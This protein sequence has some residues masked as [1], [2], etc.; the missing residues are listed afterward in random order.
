MVLEVIGR[1]WRLLGGRK[2]PGLGQSASQRE[3]AEA[4][5]QLIRTG[6]RANGERRWAEAEKAY[7]QALQ[8][9]PRL[10][11]V[12]VQYGHSLKE[13]GHFSEA[14]DAYRRAIA[15][16]DS[17]ADT[18]LQLG[19]VLKL[20]NRFDAAITAYQA[21]YTH[22]RRSQDAIRELRALGAEPVIAI[23]ATKLFDRK[24]RARPEFPPDVIATRSD[25]ADIKALY[26]LLLGRFPENWEVFRDNRNRSIAD[27]TGDLV[28]SGEFYKLVLVPL[29]TGGS[30]RHVQLEQA[31][32]E[33]VK[34]WVDRLEGD[35]GDA[36]LSWTELLRRYLDREP[37]NKIFCEAVL[38]GLQPEL[39]QLSGRELIGRLF[40]QDG[41]SIQLLVDGDVVSEFAVNGADPPQGLTQDDASRF[42]LSIPVVAFDGCDHDIVVR[43]ARTQLPVPS[44]RFTARLVPS[45]EG[46]VVGSAARLKGWVR[47]TSSSEHHVAIDLRDG[48]RV[49]CSAV[50]GQPTA[51]PLAGDHG[52][53]LAIPAIVPATARI[54]L[55][56]IPITALAERDTLPTHVSS[57]TW[58]INLGRSNVMVID[59]NATQLAPLPLGFSVDSITQGILR[60]GHRYVLDGLRELAARGD[61]LEPAVAEIFRYIAISKDYQLLRLIRSECISLIAGSPRLFQQ[62][63]MLYL[64]AGDVDSAYHLMQQ[65]RSSHREMT[66]STALVEAVLNAC[67]TQAS[68]YQDRMRLDPFAI[69]SPHRDVVNSTYHSLLAMIGRQRLLIERLLDRVERK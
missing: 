19:H 62:A 18:H 24:R 29:I 49:L 39:K 47:R 6:D 16:D 23:D 1:L 60:H 52:F 51:D 42:C 10:T 25:S 11:A 63:M 34:A 3:S 32:F 56:G 21:A 8:L 45:Y 68:R 41:I 48:E 33:L 28:R 20:Q 4:V 27:L 12:W 66:V 44:G 64:D 36:S 9:D 13:Q 57:N 35:G 31:E 61:D 50:A 14:E 69:T 37:L 59:E 58:Q 38:A 40:G 55:D 65:A 5:G 46:V 17:V 22:D 7:A 30:T 54:W 53:E 67:K 15:L 2:M 43:E 26:L